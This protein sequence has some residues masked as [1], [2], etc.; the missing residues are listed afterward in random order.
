VKSPIAARTDAATATQ[1]AIWTSVTEIGKKLE[2]RLKPVGGTISPRGS[3]AKCSAVC[4]GTPA[5]A[6]AVA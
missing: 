2:R 4:S 5:S 1:N 3:D 6:S